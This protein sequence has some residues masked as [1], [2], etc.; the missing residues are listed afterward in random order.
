MSVGEALDGLPDPNAYPALLDAD[1]ARL[2]AADLAT[3]EAAESTYARRLSGVEEDP[4]NHSAPRAVD[5]H[6][7]TSS[8]LTIH[9]AKTVARF[10]ATLPG[11]V[12][13]VSRFYRL[14]LDGPARTLRAGTGAERGAHTSP[15]PIHPQAAR[16]ITAREAARLHGYP[17]WFRFHTTNWHAHRQIG[18]SVPPPLARAAGAALMR[19]LGA[20]PTQVGA[21]SVLESD[22]TLLSMS[23][24]EASAQFDTISSELPRGRARKHPAA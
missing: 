17:D 13:P 6:V 15:R 2:V 11:R 24:T 14:P 5:R 21:T 12:E 1:Y 20:Q 16:V 19:A 18:N 8:R 10:A 4:N 3:L 9:Q 7:L 22:A 23:R